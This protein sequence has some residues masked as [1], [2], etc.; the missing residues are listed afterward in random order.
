MT[1]RLTFD[2]PTDVTRRALR[3]TAVRLTT[4]IPL[5]V[6]ALT[7]SAAMRADYEATVHR[8]EDIAD[9]CTYLHH[10]V[11]HPATIRLT[12]DP[13]PGLSWAHQDVLTVCRCCAYEGGHLYEEMRGQARTSGHVDVELMQEDGSWV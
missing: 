11:D 1:V 3:C 5:P 8:G 6:G 10:D 2:L 4:E 9:A 7:T 12:P 13:D